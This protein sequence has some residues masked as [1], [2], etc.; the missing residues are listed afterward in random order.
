MSNKPIAVPQ[1]MSR[2]LVH[3]MVAGTF[4]ATGVAVLPAISP[5]PLDSAFAAPPKDAPGT[6]GPIEVVFLV[7][8]S[9]S[10]SPEDIQSM[11]DETR[12]AIKQMGATSDVNVSAK[13][14]PFN[15]TGPAGYRTVDF[16]YQ[17]A[18]D[19]GVSTGTATPRAGGDGPRENVNVN[20]RTPGKP[21][22]DAAAAG[23]PFSATPGDAVKNE[24][25]GWSDDMSA[26]TITVDAAN[27]AAVDRA[28]DGLYR[29]RGYYQNENNPN[30]GAANWNPGMGFATNWDDAFLAVSE[31]TDF[32]PTNVVLMTD[33]VP[34]AYHNPENRGDPK[35]GQNYPNFSPDA[36]SAA[37][38][39]ADKVAVGKDGQYRT[40]DDVKI[41]AV[42]V[43]GNYGASPFDASLKAITGY[44]NDQGVEGVDYTMGGANAIAANLVNAATAKCDPAL[45]I[46]KKLTTDAKDLAPGQEISYD[47]TVRGSGNL[48]SQDVVVKDL[49]GDGIDPDSIV[50]DSVSKGAVDSADG[51]VWNVGQL[52]VGEQA[53]AKVTAKVSSS[54]VAGDNVI[55]DINVASQR[56]PDG[57]TSGTPNATVLEDDD[58]FDQ[59]V[60]TTNPADV[61]IDKATLRDQSVVAAGGK[62]TFQLTVKN[63]SDVTARNVVSKDIPGEHLTVDSISIPEGSQ[64]EI[65][66][67]DWNI[68]TLAP[69]QTV[70]AIVSATIADDWTPEQDLANDA[71]VSADG[72]EYD[73]GKTPND[74]VDPDDD[75]FDR[76]VVPPAENALKI[77]KVADTDVTGLGAGDTVEYTLTA[78]NSGTDAAPN[79]KVTD[80]P[81]AGLDPESVAFIEGSATQGTFDG[82]TWNVGTLAPGQEATIKVS[83]KI[84]EGL[85]TSDTLTNAAVIENPEHPPTGTCVPNDG[86][87][88]DDDQCDTVV[89]ELPDGTLKVAKRQITDPTEVKSGQTVYYEIEAMNDSKF[90][91]KDVLVTDLPQLGLDPDSVALSLNGTPVAD[92][93]PAKPGFQWN[94]GNLTP[95]QRIVVNVSA[96]TTA[97]ADA[98][99]NGVTIQNPENPPTGTPGEECQTNNDDV[100][101]DTDQCDVVTNDVPPI[102]PPIV[103]PT[104]T[105][106]PP[107]PPTTPPTTPPATPTTPAAPPATPTDSDDGGAS[108][109]ADDGAG[110]ARTG[111]AVGGIA[112]GGAA[113]AGLAGGV[114]AIRRRILK[115]RGE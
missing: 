27:G 89:T 90:V 52:E 49:G 71:T 73:G 70:T 103:P 85:S 91:N 99:T 37:E 40:P 1:R 6:C 63:A 83:G 78:K 104:P 82:L 26:P 5:V 38:V 61:K 62:I 113:L 96:K 48:A 107:A 30:P 87:D 22:F 75:N 7:D 44:G 64:G 109:D 67:N 10:F 56:Y 34:N 74:G 50:V 53:T 110:L 36:L 86:V 115:G 72:D 12:S 95:G 14:V 2:R 28:I 24:V 45:Q 4:A 41:N 114:A 66:G 20:W 101:A 33:G 9:N 108:T 47:V 15:A 106:E 55:N 76:E 77:D 100:T 11:L 112:L 81:G 69:G 29:D 32:N 42:G 57:P 60:T 79:V 65:S 13:I 94:V 39:T 21:D 35:E 84:A 59:E 58:R 102:V 31:I 98:Y 23:N 18:I 17:Y 111:A 88:A 43:N 19:T 68:G 93:D 97:N 92:A 8:F 80:T 51:S 105:P 54:W 25:R 3:M 16:D 46:D